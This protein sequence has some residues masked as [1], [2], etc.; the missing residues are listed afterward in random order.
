MWGNRERKKT[1]MIP[2]SLDSASGC[3]GS[4]IYQWGGGGG[5]IGRGNHEFC[6]RHV[7]VISII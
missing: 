3:L 4:T 1:G 5:A 7:E 6:F 2:G